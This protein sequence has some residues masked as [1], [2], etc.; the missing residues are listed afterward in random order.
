MT[1]S[2]DSSAAL[3]RASDQSLDHNQRR[4]AAQPD[5]ASV[6]DQDTVA[7]S[8]Q[9]LARLNEDSAERIATLK[10]QY[11]NGTYQPSW[12]ELAGKILDIHL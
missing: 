1:I 3:G 4:G 10:L 6:S 2:A 5:N 7:I 11:E 12:Q 9:I 8:S